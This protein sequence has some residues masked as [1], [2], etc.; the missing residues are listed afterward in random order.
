MAAVLTPSF[1][2]NI[3]HN[4]IDTPSFMRTE[5]NTPPR[6]SLPSISSLIKDVDEQSEKCMSPASHA[7]GASTDFSLAP[8]RSPSSDY[9]RRTSGGSYGQQPTTPDTVSFAGSPRNHLPPTPPLPGTSSF[10]FPPRPSNS[11]DSPMTNGSHPNGYFAGSPSSTNPESYATRKS[12]YPPLP[13]SNQWSAPA[14]PN[15]SRRPSDDRPVITQEPTRA[16]QSSY[17]D[18]PESNSTYSGLSQQRP[19]PANFPPPIP[20]PSSQANVPI[21]P[22]MSSTPYQH[23]HHY[24]VSNGSPYMQTTDRYQCPTCSKAFSRP[25]SLK[26]HSYSHTGE[27][28][29]RCKFD[30]CGKEFSVRSNMKRHEK[31]C[32][33]IETSSAGGS[34]PKAN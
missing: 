3:L 17:P 11:R 14:S 13:E 25:S 32:H 15:S 18:P 27:K 7:R 23:H 22:Q 2:H 33:G 12:S 8:A 31:G 20:S 5:R 30:G 26:I 21:D 28:P 10:D 24:P 34:S 6:P 19:L 16:A 29:F 9:H 1:P 4:S